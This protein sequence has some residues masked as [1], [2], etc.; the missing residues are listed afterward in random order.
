MHTYLEELNAI[1][2][3]NSNAITQ[4][5]QY[6]IHECKFRL[7][8]IKNDL[9]SGLFCIERKLERAVRSFCRD[10]SGKI[11]IWVD[12]Y[13]VAK[14]S[15]T[16]TTFHPKVTSNAIAEEVHNYLN[17]KMISFSDTW[18]KNTYASI[19]SELIADHI[20]R[21]SERKL[22]AFYQELDHV[23][24]MLT[25]NNN[26]EENYSGVSGWDRV[27]GAAVGALLM[28]PTLTPSGST[29]GLGDTTLKTLGIES[30]GALLLSLV[31][32]FNPVT[33]VAL[34]ASAIFY[35]ISSAKSGIEIEEKTKKAV[36]E[37]ASYQISKGIDK[38]ISD[39]V[40][41]TS[42]KI[43]Q[44]LIQPTIN[45]LEADLTRIENMSVCDIF[46]KLSKLDQK[47]SQMLSEL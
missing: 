45:A 12:E 38:I 20:V 21:D 32:L 13:Q 31:G 25:A 37:S 26:E 15:W 19:V 44:Q 35:N 43:R 2:V 40:S 5:T 30:G 33:A 7:E 10:L 23:S 29:H 24:V 47:C 28:D 8:N 6:S 1:I 34:I 18:S 41:K 42:D 4:A 22:N 27:K 17:Q 3:S 9:Q 11:H 14:R 46:N 36:A 39:A 16:E